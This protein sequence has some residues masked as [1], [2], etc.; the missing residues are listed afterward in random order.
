MASS[1]NTSH[2]LQVESLL[3]RERLLIWAI[4]ISFSSD[5]SNHDTLTALQHAFRLSHI[6]DALPYFNQ[7]TR[8]IASILL[9]HHKAIDLNPPACPGV[10]R[11]EWHLMQAI[12]AFQARDHLLAHGYLVAI[13]PTT[14]IRMVCNCGHQLAVMLSR[15]NFVLRRAGLP[16]NTFVQIRPE[17][18]A[19]NTANLASTPTQQ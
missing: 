1:M 18:A 13:V 17:Y 12:T 6:L 5:V 4:R 8:V 2:A 3:F 11:D 14:A 7:Y 19:A 15:K 9:E 10:G 16:I